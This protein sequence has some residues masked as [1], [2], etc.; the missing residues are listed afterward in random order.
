MNIS[1]D[2]EDHLLGNSE[3][4]VHSFLLTKYDTKFQTPK[5]LFQQLLK[6]VSRDKISEIIPTKNGI[7]IKSPEPKLATTIRNKYSFEI[8]GTQAQLTALNSPL[9]NSNHHLESHPCYQL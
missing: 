1:T 8:F 3:T 9:S 2:H 6:Y 5:C 7:I 4:Q